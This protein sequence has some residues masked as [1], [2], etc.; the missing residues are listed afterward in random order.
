MAPVNQG[1]RVR[2]IGIDVS[3][4]NVTK[5]TGVEWYAWH[6][7]QEFKTLIP[8]DVRV[9]LYSREPLLADF[10]RL[11]PNWEVRVLGWPP[12]RL[13]TQARLSWEMLV[14]PPDLLFVP[15]H[16]MPL[17]LPRRRVITLHDVAFV[18]HPEAYSRPERR[19]Q[20]FAVRYAAWRASTVLT[21][22]EFSKSELMKYFSVPERKLAVT[23]LGCEP[24]KFTPPP[25]EAFAASLERLHLAG[26]RYFLYV[27]RI[28][29]KKNV[30]GL[31]RAY[32]KYRETE[33]DPLLLVLV[34][35]PGFGGEE[36]FGLI[37]GDSVLRESV[38]C[39]GY[40]ESGDLRALYAGA[41]AF[42]FPSWY[43]GFGLPVLEAMA[44]G[45]PVVAAKAASLPEVCGE[46]A[47]LVAPEDEAGWVAAMKTVST[48]APLRARL[49]A[50][51]HDR[52]SRYSWRTT[53]ELTW[54]RISSLL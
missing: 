54:N 29:A 53:A 11:P 15:V 47:L 17:L 51:G 26:H 36:A 1:G 22:S 49:A 40:A 3:R 45:T 18:P 50:A 24:E 12:K 16:V 27:G 30:V 20:A 43:E 41:A 6:L 21:I 32:R 13:W 44:A 39:L 28:E 19:Y 23:P 7:I 5:R 9:L 34:G 38:V 33:S 2:T 37:S 52:V 14:R 31:L 48:D 35:K 46:A 4:A 25:P 42:L 8:Q 10:G